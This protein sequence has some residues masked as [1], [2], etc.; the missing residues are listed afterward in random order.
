MRSSVIHWRHCTKSSYSWLFQLPFIYSVLTP[1]RLV[2]SPKYKTLSLHLK[3]QL[4]C[5]A[6][7]QIC[8]LTLQ[9]STVLK[10]TFLGIDTLNNQ[11]RN[12]QLF[13]HKRSANCRSWVRRKCLWNVSYSKW[14][15]THTFTESIKH[16]HKSCV[17]HYLDYPK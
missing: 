9:L 8:K 3:W 16:Y 7:S 2:S 14:G 5:P 12:L 6:V 10:E 11:D 13:S 4:P 17:K 1:P 15:F